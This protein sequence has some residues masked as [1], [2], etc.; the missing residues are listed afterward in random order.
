[1]YSKSSI[2]LDRTSQ[3]VGTTGNTFTDD[4][5]KALYKLKNDIGNIILQNQ[6][7]HSEQLFANTLNDVFNCIINKN[8]CNTSI[9]KQFEPQINAIRA[10]MTAD[11]CREC[12]YFSENI[13]KNYPYTFT[14]KK[15]T[16]K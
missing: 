8:E 11:T 6:N 5:T 1:M 7:P 15:I 13:L 3:D 9:L 14:N 10:M 16:E 4:F 12:K 2:D